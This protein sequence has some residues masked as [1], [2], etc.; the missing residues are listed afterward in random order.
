FL[1]N[2]RADPP[3][4][5]A[6]AGAAAAATASATTGVSKSFLC[7]R[8]MRVLLPGMSMYR[9]PGPLCRG[10]QFRT[11]PLPA[12]LRRRSERGR[13]ELDECSSLTRI[14]PAL[15]GL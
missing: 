4:A 9:P 6:V 7:Q 14:V 15:L 10:T 11:W 12:Q 2:D 1:Q 8:P 5:S 3:P 13:S